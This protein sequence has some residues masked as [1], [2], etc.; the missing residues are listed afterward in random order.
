MTALPH[1]GAPFEGLTVLVVED[2]SIVAFL[3]EDMLLEL[4]FSK[5]WHA[6]SVAAAL[7]LLQDRRPHCA[8]LDVNL[9][10]Q[11]VY[12]VAERLRVLQAPFVFVTGYGRSGIAP[13]WQACAVLQKP[14]DL[15]PMRDALSALLA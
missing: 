7:A 12:P 10:G 13:E 6:G 4:G 5:V 3:I 15:P 1:E 8:V 2:E 11:M 14:F 9:A